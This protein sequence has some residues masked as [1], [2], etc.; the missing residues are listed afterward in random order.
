MQKDDQIGKLLNKPAPQ[1]RLYIEDQL[2]KIRRLATIGVA[3]SAEKNLERLLEMIL[4]EA[5]SFTNADGGTLYIV[6]DDE[7]ELRFAV[8]Q[9]STLNI[10]MGGTNGEITWSPVSLR[11]PDGSPNYQNVSA[12]VALS[13][14]VINIPDGYDA[15]GFNFEGTR[16][17]DA[18]TGYRSKSMLVVPMRNHENDIIG[19]LQLLNALDTVNGEIVSFSAESQQ[20]AESLA[21]QAAVALTNNRLIHGL[22]DLL[23]SFMRS[24]AVVIDEKS[25]YTGGHVR[26]VVGLTMDITHKINEVSEGPYAATY[27]NED[28][29]R[30]IKMA[31]WLHDVGKVTTPE[32][33]IDKATKL[34]TVFDRIELLKIRFELLKR[35][36]E[37]RLVKQDATQVNSDEFIKKLKD[38]LDFLVKIN[39]GS[40]YM[41][42]EMVKRVRDIAGTQLV[43]D[44]EQRSILTDDEISNLSVKSGTLTEDERGLVN[45][46]SS[47]TYKILSQLPF[48]KKLKNVPEYAASHHERLDG[49]GYPLGLKGVV[50]GEG[51][52]YEQA[53]ADVKS[54]IRFHIKTFGR[55]VLRGQPAVLDAFVA[56]AAVS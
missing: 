45:N 23:E 1:I 27:F 11:N 56:E 46:H 28:A 35:D 5:R 52:T 25:P 8:V 40:G 48:P 33:I 42:E 49:S 44:G 31:A 3:L 20:M 32:Y 7:L 19:V 54:A 34:E 6:S 18:K 2:E 53:L 12:Y 24:I 47:V 21:S 43:I 17:F 38:D 14:K 30:E 4:E 29:M 50:V 22:E 51:D 26:R 41:S 16:S 39:Y 10:R 37:F 36:H 15:D 9:S 13:G 55:D